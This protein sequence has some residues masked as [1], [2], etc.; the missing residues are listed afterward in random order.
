M[1]TAAQKTLFNVFEKSSVDNG[2]VSYSDKLSQARRSGASYRAGVEAYER[3][4]MADR[5][6]DDLM[7]PYQD[8]FRNQTPAVLLALGDSKALSRVIIKK[9][10]VAE[11][12]QR[13]ARYLLEAQTKDEAW[14][15]K[16]WESFKADMTD[17]EKEY[18]QNWLDTFYKAQ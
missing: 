1:K 16:K 15:L 11:N 7:K 3:R 8:T 5:F 4:E 12:E 10:K 14:L 13:L 2:I 18:Y 17:Q 6:G 9:M